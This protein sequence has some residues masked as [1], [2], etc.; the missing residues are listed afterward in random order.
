MSAVSG[1]AGGDDLSDRTS[2]QSQIE[3]YADRDSLVRLTFMRTLKGPKV[4]LLLLPCSR[5]R[6]NRCL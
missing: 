4:A 5:R 2:G 1:E 6:G 3:Y